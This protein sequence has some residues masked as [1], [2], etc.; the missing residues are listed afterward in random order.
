MSGEPTRSRFDAAA[1]SGLSAALLLDA[2][3]AWLVYAGRAAHPAWAGLLALGL[4]LA[5]VGLAWAAGRRRG[6]DEDGRYLSGLGALLVLFLPVLGPLGCVG[7][8]AAG[9]GLLKSRGLAQAFSGQSAMDRAAGDGRGRDAVHLD[10]ELSIQPVADILEGGDAALKRGAIQL[11]RRL[12]TKDAVRLLRK[13]L[14]DENPEVRFYAHTAL[15]RLEEDHAESMALAHKR[16]SDAD[17]ESLVALART[18]RRYADSGLPDENISRQSIEDARDNLRQALDIAGEA[19][20][21][22]RVEMGQ[23]E[24]HLGHLEA[25]REQFELA[26]SVQPENADAVLGLL[27]VRFRERDLAGL[28]RLREGLAGRRFDTADP[29]RL[30]VLNFWAGTLSRRSAHA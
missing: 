12:G 11:L 4:H 28:Q 19:Q 5:G 13:S 25:A 26:L 3:A 1:A 15:T 18:Q 10:E 6:A 2:A 23:L 24:L 21:E 8:M 27:E 14:S 20:E 22:W 16:A 30:V 9:R 7:A 17:P 29:E